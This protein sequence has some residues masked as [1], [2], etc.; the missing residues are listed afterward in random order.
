MAYTHMGYNQNSQSGMIVPSVKPTKV[1]QLM[2]LSPKKQANEEG[3]LPE[4][5]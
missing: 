2:K 5:V 4:G 3:L 1:T